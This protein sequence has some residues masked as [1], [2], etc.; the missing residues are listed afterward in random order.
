MAEVLGVVSSIATL[1]AIAQTSIK[2]ILSFQNAPS[3]ILALSN[4]ACDLSIVASDIE[5]LLKHDK[6]ARPA[7]DNL[8][9][10]VLAIQEQIYELKGFVNNISRQNVKNGQLDRIRWVF[11]K[12][13]AKVLQDGLRR[14]KQDLLAVLMSANAWDSP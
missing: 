9:R 12:K 7:T 10:M 3:E 4:E 8:E 2:T 6:R 14:A 11:E 13:K 5:A 1:V